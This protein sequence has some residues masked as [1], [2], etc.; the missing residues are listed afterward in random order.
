MRLTNACLLRMQADEEKFFACD[1][2]FAPDDIAE[3][4]LRTQSLIAPADVRRLFEA[5][6]GRELG[7][8]HRDVG[9]VAAMTTHVARVAA[10]FGAHN[11]R[12]APTYVRA[13]FVCVRE[14]M[15]LQRARDARVDQASGAV[16]RVMAR[17]DDA[18]SERVESIGSLCERATAFVNS[19]MLCDGGIGQIDIEVLVGGAS[20]FFVL[21][22]SLIASIACYVRGMLTLLTPPADADANPLLV[23][24]SYFGAGLAALDQMRTLVEVGSNVNKAVGLR[25]PFRIVRRFFIGFFYCLMLSFDNN[26]T[27]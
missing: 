18:S 21:F 1:A 26:R 27:F 10:L 23:A 5:R 19:A 14:A 6:L 20:A 8:A 24:E 15:R 3:L 13:A 12:S 22:C 11:Q 16:R 2:P 7:A 25:H 4:V 9:L 17:S